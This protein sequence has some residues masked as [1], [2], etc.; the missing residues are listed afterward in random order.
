M[1]FPTEP[2]PFRKNLFKL[3]DVLRV[4]PYPQLQP[5]D[6]QQPPVP[7]GSTSPGHPAQSS[8]CPHTQRV[9]ASCE[10]SPRARQ[11]SAGQAPLPPRPRRAAPCPVP[12]LW[13]PHIC[14]PAV[15]WPQHHEERE[16]VRSPSISWPC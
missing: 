3:T 2:L 11:G 16:L 8:L 5:S 6:K 15:P 7:T 13:P 14:H 12:P 1:K 10:G 4:C 9:Q